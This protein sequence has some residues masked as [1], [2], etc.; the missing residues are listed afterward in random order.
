MAQQIMAAAAGVGPGFDMRDRAWRMGMRG[1]WGQTGPDAVFATNVALAAQGIGG[2]IA[3]VAGRIPGLRHRRSYW[4][5]ISGQFGAAEGAQVLAGGLQGGLGGALTAAG[6]IAGGAFGPIGS[7]LGGLLGGGIGRLFGKKKQNAGLTPA[8]PI[9]T[10]DVG[11][12]EVLSQLLNV[13]KGQ[14]IGGT[15]R[16]IDRATAQLALQ[17]ARV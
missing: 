3:G 13:T 15:G 8:Q 10:R 12:M 17:G 7:L 11:V 4:D 9:Y 6:S 2:D 14:L 1:R 16:G 5:Q